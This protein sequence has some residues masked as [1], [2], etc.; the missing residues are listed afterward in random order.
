MPWDLGGRN[1]M[2]FTAEQQEAIDLLVANAK[3]GLFTKE[4]LDRQVTAE[5][6]R[7]VD[8]GIKNGV[9]KERLKWEKDFASKAAL[10]AEERIQQEFEEKLKLVDAREKELAKRSNNLEA[11]NM[12]VEA[13]LQK[14]DYE[15]FI[16]L[17]VTDDA[18]Q[19]QDNVKN[20]ITTFTE[21]Q[22]AIE[23]R[24]KKELS[25]I[26]PPTTNPDGNKTITKESFAAMGYAERLKLKQES[27][28]LYES[29]DL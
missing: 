2:E 15:K 21:T 8:S 24:L 3:A 27:P 9:E 26:T 17:L 25:V 4:D 1:I 14:A 5:V 23:S 12:F 28:Q 13:G 19:T 22:S 29:L 7:R 16:S 10:S 20:F 6:D 18:K 11:Q